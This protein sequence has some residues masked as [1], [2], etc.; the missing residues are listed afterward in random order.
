[1]CTYVACHLQCCGP[2]GLE[3]HRDCSQSVLRAVVLVLRALVL[4]L[5]LATVVLVLRAVVLVIG[6]SGLGLEGCG[7]GHWQQWS[8]S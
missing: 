8:W 1:M 7:L 2:L 4:I 6:N 5:V 3:A